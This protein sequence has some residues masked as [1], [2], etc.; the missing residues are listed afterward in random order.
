M[1]IEVRISGNLAAFSR[2]AATLASQSRKIIRNELQKSGEK[3]RTDVRKAL[4]AQTGAKR[5]GTIVKNTR[6]YLPNDTTFVIAT[7]GR[8]LPIEEFPLKVSRNEKLRQRWSRREHWKLQGRT[9]N[10]RFGKIDSRFDNAK[11]VTASPWGVSRAFARSFGTDQGPRALVPTKNGGK[12]IRKLFG[13]SLPKEIVKGQTARTFHSAARRV[14]DELI[15]KL[16]AVLP[17]G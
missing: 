14:G 17:K 10:G 6:S 8:G 5:Y 4:Q 1:E 12:A 3:L 7:S 13:P 9:G 15:A 16:A 2:G 11:G